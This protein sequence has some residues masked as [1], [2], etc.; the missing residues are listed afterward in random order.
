MAIVIFK[1]RM[2]LPAYRTA[3]RCRGRM[4]LR[5]LWQVRTKNV[6]A[7]QEMATAWDYLDVR[8][9][10][11]SPNQISTGATYV[12]EMI[13]KV[14]THVLCF[15]LHDMHFLEST[16][17]VYSFRCL[18]ESACILGNGL[19]PARECSKYLQPF[20]MRTWPIYVYA[21][22][23]KRCRSHTE[24]DRTH[25]NTFKITSIRYLSG[26]L[27]FAGAMALAAAGKTDMQEL[28]S[29]YLYSKYNMTQTTYGPEKNPSMAGGIT[30]TGQDFVISC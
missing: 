17:L 3:K 13:F 30:T 9:A 29:T 27:Q 28:F 1:H 7:Y 11:I 25:V 6:W 23:S 15:W 19:L 18:G 24:H 2:S 4:F 16:P 10:P 26:H 22:I 21:V 12:G 5:W 8:H 20:T 14:C